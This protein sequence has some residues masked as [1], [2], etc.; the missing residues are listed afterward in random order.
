MI[1]YNNQLN[2]QAVEKANQIMK[3]STAKLKML[4]VKVIEVGK[5]GT[6]IVRLDA[7]GLV[8]Y[9]ADWRLK[10]MFK[11]E[12]DYTYKL[13]KL[14]EGTPNKELLEQVNYEKAILHPFGIVELIRRQPKI[15]FNGAGELEAESAEYKPLVFNKDGKILIDEISS[16]PIRKGRDFT[17]E[18]DYEIKI[19]EMRARLVDEIIRHKLT[20]DNLAEVLEVDY[21]K[22]EAMGYGTTH[23]YDMSRQKLLGIDAEIY[24]SFHLITIGFKNDVNSSI[25]V[26]DTEGNVIA[27]GKDTVMCYVSKIIKSRELTDYE[28]WLFDNMWV[29]VVE[30]GLIMI[31]EEHERYC[32]YLIDVPKSKHIR[33]GRNERLSILKKEILKEMAEKLKEAAKFTGD[34]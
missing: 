14:P 9:T 7:D 32:K 15:T 4:G 33:A 34:E 26:F 18:L 27:Y 17:S 21:E 23:S 25:V 13:Q 24:D 11:D 16:D 19:G 31:D 10:G 20:K 6:R 1:K 29:A 22:R 2:R 30:D 12:K 5:K 3:I 8:D 28:R